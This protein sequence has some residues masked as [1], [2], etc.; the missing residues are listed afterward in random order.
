ML[1]M[2]LALPMLLFV[3]ALIIDAGAVATW[4][5]RELTIARLAVWQTRWPR[6]GTTD[7]QPAYWPAAGSMGV[8]SAGNESALDDPRVD[9]PVA[10]GPL[11]G[12]QVDNTLLD[13]TMG[14]SEGTATM[15]RAY[16]LLPKLG[17]YTI[18]E[19]TYL[20]DDKWQYQRTKLVNNVQRRIPAIYTLAQAP[21]SLMNAYVESVMAIVNAPF[22]PQL[23]P[24]DRDPDFI[25]YNAMFGWG[26]PPDFQPRIQQFC[27]LDHSQ[28][29]AAVQDVVGQIQG[30]ATYPGGVPAKMTSAFLNLYN[31]VMAAY[32][33]MANG[34]SPPADTGQIQTDINE[35]QQFQGQL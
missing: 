8:A 7:P 10:R 31:R 21:A 2:I 34:Q 3:M 5:A 25:M 26:P 11:Q 13:P 30:S 32:Q 15:T 27:S 24:L 28:A 23:A 35:L 1:E 33:A 19:T 9:L 14:L 6:T 17:P 4:K 20:L 29:D 16:P 22:W 12:A 18:S